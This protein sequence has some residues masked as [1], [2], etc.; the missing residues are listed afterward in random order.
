MRNP[1]T[2]A[3]M[4]F[5]SAAV[6]ACSTTPE[7]QYTPSAPTLTVAQAEYIVTSSLG[8]GRLVSVLDD[9]YYRTSQV[10]LRPDGVGFL[11]IRGRDPGFFSTK[12]LEYDTP[13]QLKVCYYAQASTPTVGHYSMDDKVFVHGLC[14]VDV[15]FRTLGEAQQFAD[16]LFVLE[17]AQR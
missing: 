17:H 15:W 3:A 1:R 2:L 13:P 9:A 10:K 6:L 5:A 7:V 16:A 12:L 14:N 11:W 4:L 8:A